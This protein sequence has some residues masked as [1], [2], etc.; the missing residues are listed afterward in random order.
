M[1]PPGAQLALSNLRGADDE[2]ENPNAPRSPQIYE[3]EDTT[4]ILTIRSADMQ[5]KNLYGQI[6]TTLPTEQSTLQLIPANPAH[7]D[8]TTH[9]DD[10]GNFEFLDIVEDD[11]QLLCVQDEQTIV[12]PVLSLQ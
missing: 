2:Q 1:N 12:I 6:L 11:Y 4:I 8:L 9:L 10:V 3:F 5:R 7:K